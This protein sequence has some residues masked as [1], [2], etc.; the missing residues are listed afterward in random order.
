MVPATPGCEQRVSRGTGTDTARH[1]AAPG[2][3]RSRPKP[4][5]RSLVFSWR[6]PA[7]LPAEIVPRQSR[8]MNRPYLSALVVLVFLSLAPSRTHAQDAATK[9]LQ[10]RVDSLEQLVAELG[11]RVA[12]LESPAMSGATQTRTATGDSRNLA[13]WRRLQEGMSYDQ[14][15]A[16]LGEPTKVDGGTVA[17][18]EY[19]RHGSVSFYSG[20]VSS[21]SEPER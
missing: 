15:R 10:Q 17:R 3:H 13:N 12:Q 8:P 20:R 16:L 4:G 5:M 21:W 18:W 6:R 14:V 11:R 7:L 1:Q 9:R 2:H 19:P